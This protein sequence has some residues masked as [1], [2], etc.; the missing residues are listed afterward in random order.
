MTEPAVSVNRPM[1]TMEATERLTVLA[2]ELAWASEETRQRCMVRDGFR[3]HSADEG[4]ERLT[5]FQR[6]QWIRRAAALLARLRGTGSRCSWSS[7]KT[8]S[9]QRQSDE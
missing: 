7:A 2:R 8:M 9:M 3:D 6:D 5:E 1:T 4:W